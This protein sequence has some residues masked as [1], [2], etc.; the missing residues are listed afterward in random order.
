MTR[1]W[2]IKFARRGR[3]RWLKPA[4]RKGNGHEFVAQ[5]AMSPYVPER[6]IA[7][8]SGGNAM[9]GALNEHF[10]ED[11]ATAR[12]GSSTVKAS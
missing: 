5:L 4:Q 1:H 10:D 9:L 3:H 2:E 6:H 7:A 11:G 8:A 12:L